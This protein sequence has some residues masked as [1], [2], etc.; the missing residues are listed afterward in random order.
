MAQQ[1]TLNRMVL[2]TMLLP[3]GKAELKPALVVGVYQETT[4]GGEVSANGPSDV[5]NSSTVDLCIF[6][7]G[8]IMH[9]ERVPYSPST[10]AGY[11]SWP[12]QAGPTA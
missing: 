1:V 8:G 9:Q 2:M 10:Q 3:G 12:R 11:W 5:P 6:M 4:A 7:R